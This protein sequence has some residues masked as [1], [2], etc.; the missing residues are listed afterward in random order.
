MHPST[1]ERK[2]TIL[3]KEHLRTVTTSFPGVPIT[4]STAILTVADRTNPL[5]HLL[6]PIFSCR[7]ISGSLNRP[8]LHYSVQAVHMF[9]HEQQLIK[10]YDFRLDHFKQR[11][12]PRRTQTSHSGIIYCATAVHCIEVTKTVND[13]YAIV[14]RIV[15]VQSE[16][17]FLTICSKDQSVNTQSGP[18]T[19]PFKLPRHYSGPSPVF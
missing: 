14:I 7:I 12:G 13:T 1:L 8:N 9:R 5:D 4:T 11:P 16:Q 3:A 15:Y 18:P 17:A 2:L 10:V 6:I 19:G